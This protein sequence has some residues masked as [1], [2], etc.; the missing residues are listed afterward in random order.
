MMPTR[1][2]YSTIMAGL[3]ATSVSAAHAAPDSGSLR[4]Q[5]I[6]DS[7]RAPLRMDSNTDIGVPDSPDSFDNPDRIRVEGYSVHGNTRLSE[8]AIKDVL[9]PYTAGDFTVNQ[10]HDAAN[11]LRQRYIDDGLFAAEVII[12]PQALGTDHIVALYVYEGILARDGVYLVNSGERVNDAVISSVLTDNLVGG[13]HLERRNIE[14]AILLTGDLPGITVNG[15][16][17]PGPAE[18]EAI[19][20][21]ETTDLPLVSG[22]VFTDN[23]GNYYTGEAR[24][25]A[26]VSIDSPTRRGDRIVLEAITSGERSNYAFAQYDLPVGGSGL[27][28]GASADYLDYHLGEE[29]RGDNLEG[30]AAEIRLLA[31]YPVIRARHHNL[32]LSAHL[33]RLDLNDRNDSSGRSDR[34]INQATLG[35]SGDAETRLVRPGEFLFGID[36]SVGDLSIIAGDAFER[37]DDAFQKSAGSYARLGYHVSHLQ[38]LAGALSA[39]VSLSG[40]RANGNLDTSQKFYIGGPYDVAGYPISE[41]SGDQGYLAHADL[42][43]DLPPSAALGDTQV[44]LFY[45]Y[46]EVEIYKNPWDGWQGGNS[47]IRNRLSL[48]SAGLSSHSVWQGKYALHLMLGRQLG[49]SYASDPVTFRDSDQSDNSYRAWIQAEYLF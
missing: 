35:L 12:P 20:Q 48:A 25:G 34:R 46:G 37:F 22:E 16:L 32:Y 44:A 38:H 4:N 21:L 43:Y 47:L 6:D 15:T 26:Q 10:I 11:A 5:Q 14:R 45:A 1:L 29:L 42:R 7:D 28:L 30:S 41:A 17:S 31:S 18:G 13:R 33:G 24:L 23:F 39:Y 2:A 3:L 36:V 27:R 19:F 8:D 49:K 9:A 40:Q